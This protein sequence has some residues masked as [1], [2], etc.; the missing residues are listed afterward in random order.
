MFKFPSLEMVQ[1]SLSSYAAGLVECSV[2]PDKIMRCVE[3]ETIVPND[4]DDESLPHE[5]IADE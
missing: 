4:V 2:Y 5:F 1:T 3:M